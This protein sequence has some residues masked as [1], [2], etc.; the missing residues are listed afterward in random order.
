M[1]S[2]LKQHD[3]LKVTIVK[4]GRCEKRGAY[5]HESVAR[6][7]IKFIPSF[8]LWHEDAEGPADDVAA[9][10]VQEALEAIPEGKT[11][12]TETNAVDVHSQGPVDK[13]PEVVEMQT[14]AAIATRTFKALRIERRFCQ[15]G[16][17]VT[18]QR[19][20]SDG[21]FNATGMCK[22]FQKLFADYMRSQRASE[23]L[24]ALVTALANAGNVTLAATQ[25]AA[26]ARH[27]EMGNPMSVYAAS[28]DSL[29]KVQ[30]GGAYQ[31]SWIHE[32]VAVDLA[33]WLSPTFA[34]WIDGWVEAPRVQE[35]LEVIP[36]EQT[37]PTET[38]AVD[39]H[40][41]GPVDKVP[42]VVEM[43][44]ETSITTRTFKGLMI[45]RRDSDG[46]FNG[47]NICT[48]FKK[49]FANYLRAER[50]SE[51]L[52]A[53]AHSLISV[54]RNRVTD[55]EQTRA[56]LVQVQRGGASQGSWIHERVAVDLA[57][58]L[59][60]DFAV[61]MDGWVLGALGLSSAPSTTPSALGPMAETPALTSEQAFVPR[62]PL[63]IQE[64]DSVGLPG[65]D[66]LYAAL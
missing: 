42:E 49:R 12:P 37:G 17:D 61:W 23:Y 62:K 32:R 22:G 27:T 29:V 6:E 10:R 26:S 56:S 7:L 48:A 33:R 40:S 60:P 47:T 46:Y 51:Y 64:E 2:L 57:R 25:E 16:V 55:F 52:D 66:H 19:R 34:I 11:G 58:W 14:E 13:V 28:R 59:S 43:Q 44:T 45:E 41:Q 63:V 38:N 39:V 30:K 9:P 20:D 8:H 15:E 4:N 65:N 53:L 3:V 18:I 21:Y 5:A 36:E 24:D 35:A 1:S 50:V 54:T 31:G